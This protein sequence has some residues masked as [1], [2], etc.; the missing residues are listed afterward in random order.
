M[1]RLGALTSAFVVDF[2]KT[3]QMVSVAAQDHLR[4]LIDH[5]AYGDHLMNSW[6]LDVSTL[7]FVLKGN[8]PYGYPYQRKQCALL[9]Y[10]LG[11]TYSKESVSIMLNLQKQQKQRYQALEDQLVS[12]IVDAMGLVEHHGKLPKNS[13]TVLGYLRTAKIRYNQLQLSTKS[14]IWIWPS[15]ENTKK[16]CDEDFDQIDWIWL[17]LSTQLIYFV[18]FQFVSFP[19]VTMTLYKKVRP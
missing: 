8:L 18:L 10:V 5:F 13:N 17:H 19:H 16:M 15:K 3:A 12:M 14:P 7:K 1:Q 6:K 4:P 2:C 9:E 11:Q